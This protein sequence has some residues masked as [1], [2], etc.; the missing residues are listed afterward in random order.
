LDWIRFT[1][2]FITYLNALWGFSVIVYFD[3]NLLFNVFND[4]INPL[5]NLIHTLHQNFYIYY[6]NF[7]KS[8][9]IYIESLITID[10]PV[11]TENNDE[12]YKS[13]DANVDIGEYKIS[14]KDY[15][16]VNNYHKFLSESANDTEL[17]QK[18]IDKNHSS[19]I[20]SKYFYIPCIL[21]VTIGGG[22]LIIYYFDV[23]YL[24]YITPVGFFL[25]QTFNYIRGT[26]NNN[27]DENNENDEPLK[28]ILKIVNTENEE[29]V[30]SNKESPTLS[31]DTDIGS[32]NTTSTDDTIKPSPTQFDKYFKQDDGGNK[33]SKSRDHFPATLEQD[34]TENRDSDPNINPWND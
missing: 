31:E 23:D 2:K 11:L 9:K 22:G 30:E 15:D 17:K 10:K 27:I 6:Q 13:A 16:H 33:D 19:F 25:Q 26:T 29:V 1:V 4:F 12:I 24:S 20:Y 21:I 14:K 5:K 3:T 32:P 18:I 34:G 8:L 7:L 28:I